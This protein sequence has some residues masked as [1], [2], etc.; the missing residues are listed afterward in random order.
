MR[1]RILL[2]QASQKVFECPSSYSRVDWGQG[3]FLLTLRNLKIRAEIRDFE[4][5]AGGMVLSAQICNKQKVF[6]KHAM[7]A[8]TRGI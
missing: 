1:D 2:A 5:P 8:S 7:K 6:R 3:L 4:T